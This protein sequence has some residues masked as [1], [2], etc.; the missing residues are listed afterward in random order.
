[1]GGC[2]S[3]GFNGKFSARPIKSSMVSSRVK[4][5][6]NTSVDVR[7][8]Y[9][10]LEIIGQ[11][12]YGVVRQAIRRRDY[13]RVAIKSIAKRNLNRDL[14][15]MRRELDVLQSVDHP[16]IIR[17]Y[18]TY[19]DEKYLHIVSELCTGGELLDHLLKKGL[20]PEAETAQLLRRLFSGVHHLHTLKI[21]HRDL[22][23]DN[24]LFSNTQTLS[25]IKLAD[26][27][28]SC[29]FLN[30]ETKL[31]SLVGTPYYVAPEVITGSYSSQCDVWSL[32]VMMYFLL[33]GLQPFA[34]QGVRE[35]MHLIVSGKYDFI[36][37]VWRQISSD[38]EDL[39]RKMLVLDPATRLTIPQI[40]EHSW[41]TT[42]LSPK[43]SAVPMAMLTSL[44]QSKAQNRLVKETVKLLV[45]YTTSEDIAQLT[46][47]FH[48]LDTEQTGFITV[49]SL[50]TA[51]QRCGVQLAL[52]EVQSNSYIEIIAA[53]DYGSG[54]IK[55]SDFLAS[56]LS[57][58]NFLNEESIWAA[59]KHFDTV[60]FTQTN[61]GFINSGSIKSALEEN[62]CNLS[63][64]ELEQILS[65]FNLTKD[66]NLDFETY[67]KMIECF[68]EDVNDEIH[69]TPLRITKARSKSFQHNSRRDSRRSS[70]AEKS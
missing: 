5:Q 69:L 38:A 1:M 51:L 13:Q 62:S 64:A 32:G 10:F 9:R 48:M 36:A 66:S 7:E 27:G 61:S 24:V 60:F 45:C 41:F 20:L 46:E 57:M 31:N 8:K 35:T 40:L 43:P 58:Q 30:E 3:N 23:P 44:K 25:D 29:K 18:E 28:L 4:V 12:Q 55:Y 63:D 22:K 19:E 21:V 70:R 52:G 37:P 59:F 15:L 65:E 53:N 14:T 39:I 42:A 54:H 50:E 34:S 49:S 56:I 2:C 11:G 33:S 68:Q 6:S 16:N 67:R 26:F 17:L 47:V